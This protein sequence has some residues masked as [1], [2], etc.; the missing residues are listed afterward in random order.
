MS[1]RAMGG[2]RKAQRAPA[3]AACAR[4]CRCAGFSLLLAG[5]GDAVGDGSMRR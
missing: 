3:E 2:A 5:A 4:S 1:D